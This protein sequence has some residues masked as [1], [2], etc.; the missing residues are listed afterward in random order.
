MFIAVYPLSRGLIHC[1]WHSSNMLEHGKQVVEEL[2][3]PVTMHNP[4]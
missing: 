4:L 2:L 3:V 1:F